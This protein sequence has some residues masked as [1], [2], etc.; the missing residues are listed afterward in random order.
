MSDCSWCNENNCPATEKNVSG[1][2]RWFFAK[3]KEQL[4]KEIGQKCKKVCLE[5][6]RKIN[7][8]LFKDKE[9]GKSFFGRKFENR[10][11][12]DVEKRG[13]KDTMDKYLN[14]SGRVVE[15]P[16]EDFNF[17]E[18]ISKSET[19]YDKIRY[20]NNM[21]SSQLDAIKE[22]QINFEEY[23][24]FINLPEALVSISK[25]A[26]K[27]MDAILMTESYLRGDNFITF[28]VC[29]MSAREGGSRFPR[30][31]HISSSPS[32]GFPG[33]EDENRLN[34]SVKPIEG[35]DRLNAALINEIVYHKA[36]DIYVV[37]EKMFET[38]PWFPEMWEKVIT[39]YDPN[40]PPSLEGII[41]PNNCNSL[42]IYDD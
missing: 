23:P 4:V 25:D 7:E 38:Q 32:F 15:V 27:I 33:D 36:D 3:S 9:K 26:A 21:L 10:D 8:K 31:N 39:K 24:Q 41:I 29:V 34:S 11:F 37:N 22:S 14:L 1:K 30:I 40:S 13:L 6:A 20:V 17:W 42:P 19:P 16:G 18:D 12:S 2:N 35:E 5:C 28:L